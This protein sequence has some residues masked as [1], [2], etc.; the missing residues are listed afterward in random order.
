MCVKI[1]LE[2]V[3][4]ILVSIIITRIRVKLTLVYVE[5]T[6]CVLNLPSACR[7]LTRACRHHTRKCQNYTRVHGSLIR[8]CV[9]QTLRVYIALY[10]LEIALVRV[11]FRYMCTLHTDGWSERIG[12]TVQHQNRSYYV[13]TCIVPI[14]AF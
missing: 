5:I 11:E 7:N 3:V 13:G 9:N 4:I 1:T 14:I 12:Q 6:L 10:V 2:R 8:A